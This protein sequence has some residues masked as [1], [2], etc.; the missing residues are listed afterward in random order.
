MHEDRLHRPDKLAVLVELL[1]TEGASAADALAGSGLSAA[2]LHDADTRVSVRQMLAVYANAQ[3]LSRDPALALRAGA[4]IRI[5]HF[6]LY[7]YA[8]LAS[9]SAR[10]A[11]DFALRYRALASPVIG[12]SF[13][14]DGQ[15]AVWSFDDVMGIGD[16]S[17][18]FRFV[19]EMQL[20]TQLALHRDLLGT[21]LTPTRVQLR[22]AAPAHADS[23]REL[24]GC[25]ISFDAPGHELR[26]DA[27][28]LDHPLVFANPLDGRARPADL[29]QAARRNE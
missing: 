10:Q 5:T 23:Y 7:G 11:I 20:G 8:L 28:W 25:P 4:R 3:R 6:G 19:V 14:L 9:P 26:F 18:L 1:V 29:R 27:A 2:A 16:Q 12:L 22:Y 15:E 24:L 13:R 21:A 17:D